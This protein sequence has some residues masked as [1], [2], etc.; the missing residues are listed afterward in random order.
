MRA[1]TT[2]GALFLHTTG[3]TNT[4]LGYGA[5]NSATS[6]IRNTGFGLEALSAN[7]TGDFNTAF[8]ERALRDNTTGRY[9]TAF[10]ASALAYAMTASE[11]SAFRSEALRHATTGSRNSAFGQTALKFNST[12]SDNSAFGEG[13]LLANTQGSL[14]SAFGEDALRSNTTGLSNSAFGR[15]ALSANTTSALSSAFG[16]GALISSTGSRNTAVGGEAGARLTTGSFNA[17]LGT[18]VG[19]YT[20]TGSDNAFLG[21]EAGSTNTTGDR[22]T[23]IG[24]RANVGSGGLTNATAVGSRAFVAQASSLVLGSVNGVNNATADTDVGIATAA[25]VERLH[26]AANAGQVLLGDA[27]CNAGFKGIGFG[28]T[29][30]GCSDFAL[31]GNGDETVV[32]RSSGSIL[33]FR[34][35]GTTEQMRLNANGTVLLN[36]LGAAGATALCQN[37]SSEIAACSSSIRYKTNVADFDPGVALIERLR[38]ISFDWN[39]FDW[40]AGGPADLG[41]IAEEVAEIEPRLTSRNAAGEIEG[42]KYD[43]VGVVLVNAVQEQQARIEAQAE[44]LAALEAQLF[45]DRAAM[46]E[47]RRW[48]CRNRSAAEPCLA[49]GEAATGAV[50]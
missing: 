24:S 30:S 5:G 4:F 18:G 20:T 46:A 12:G 26:V 33:S 34:I 17:M 47:L 36:T 38:P 28:S 9:Q 6:G 15:G 25:P 19:F 10:G 23:M 45:R 14:N 16:Q 3:G 48:V 37:G 41:L 35:N 44:K 22:N 42:V 7:T 13:A 8:G 43:R 32:N 11:N 49:G 50:E 31:L 2:G 39:S 40:K 1:L 29:L 27:G 21:Q